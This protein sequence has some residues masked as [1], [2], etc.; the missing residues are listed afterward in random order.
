MA[1][2][3]ET[4]WDA[5]SCNDYAT[6]FSTEKKNVQMIKALK[7]KYPDEVEIVMEYDDDTGIG[8]MAHLPKAWCKIS[9]KRKRNITPE[10]L[11]VLR[12]RMELA[13]KKK[14]GVRSSDSG[15]DSRSET[16]G[17]E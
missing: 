2:I 1:D 11:E 3:K 16:N 13:R 17:E 10:E 15:S 14:S 5:L 12:E 4:S 9:P 7:E 6:Y 8:V